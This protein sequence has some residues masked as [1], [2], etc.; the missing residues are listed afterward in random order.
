MRIDWEPVILL[1]VLWIPMFIV[2]G[3]M[4]VF[5]ETCG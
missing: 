1:A 3:L 2:L 4:V 5:G